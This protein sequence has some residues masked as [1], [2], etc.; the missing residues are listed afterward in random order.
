MPGMNWSNITTWVLVALVLCAFSYDVLASMVS[1]SSATISS[2]VLRTAR[3]NPILPY[4][5]G[6]LMGHLVWPQ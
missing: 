6:L 2:V 3:D 4:L 5:L 1:G